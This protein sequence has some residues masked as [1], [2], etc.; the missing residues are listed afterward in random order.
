MW[1]DYEL[2]QFYPR[3]WQLNYYRSNHDLL[4][5]I[6]VWQYWLW[7]TFI[8]LINVY[9]VLLF[10]TFS[11]KRA[12]V[13]GRR[14][15]GDKRHGSWPEIFT[16]FFPFLWVINILS[17]SLFI[18][19]NLE[20]NGGYP[21]F[22]VQISA[23]Q[24]GWHYNYGELTYF[25]LLAT[26]IKVGFNTPFAANVTEQNQSSNTP[27]TEA[28]F[29][30]Q[31]TTTL[32]TLSYADE[33]GMK[34][35]IYRARNVISSQGLL[36]NSLVAQLYLDKSIEFVNNPLR[37]LSANNAAVLP[38]R[39]VV[40]LLATA[41]DV[42]HSWALPGLGIKLDCVPGRLYVS[43]VNIAREGVYYG[44]CSELC[45][46]THFNMP[47]VL[48]AIPFEHFLLWWE[49]EFN[50]TFKNKLEMLNQHYKLVSVKYK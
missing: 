24:W 47:V 34:V 32:G 2:L 26:P 10:R 40:R 41:E 31:W 49:I 15:V 48:Y 39:A 22:T 30:R 19:Q 4:N 28:Q 29:M 27:L 16:C 46:W 9:F 23:Y 12:D 20:S 43:F 21:L 45:G 35:P 44:Q 18:L 33:F 5:Y 13:R 25:K 7:F 14:S 17:N 50:A 8:F 38:T 3:N 36:P 11:F 1:G 6:S 37:L 42:I